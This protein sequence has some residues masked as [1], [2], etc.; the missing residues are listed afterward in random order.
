MCGRFTLTVNNRID[1]KVLGL[2][3]K[4]RFNIAPQSA[5]LVIDAKLEKRLITWNY[6]PKWADPPMHLSNARSE[7]LREKPSFKGAK[8]C[9]FLADG[10]YEWQRNPGRKIPYYH[11]LDGELLYF[12]GIYNETSGAAIVT[13]DSVPELAE[14][15]HRQ[16]VVLD[17]R[18]VEHWIEGHDLYASA[19]S[20]RIKTHP[21]S[22][23]VNKPENDD[24]ALI[25]PVTLNQIRQEQG[26]ARHRV[27]KGESGDLFE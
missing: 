5:V 23:R 8:R 2:G 19:I 6:S 15:H 25:E 13:R 7:T 11:H 1:L 12:A 27:H 22:T 24:A 26:E 21:V 3:L 9:V 16:P 17:P 4:D 10:W 14:I 20:H 18:A